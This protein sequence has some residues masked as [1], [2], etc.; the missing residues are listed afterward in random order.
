[1]TQKP[2]GALILTHLSGE[3][4]CALGKVLA[5]RGFRIKTRSTPNLDFAE[6]EALRPDLLVVMGGPVGVYQQEDY[7]FLKSEIEILKKRLAADKPTIGICL[8]SQ[9]MAAALGGKVYAGKQGKEL[10]WM[11]LTLT[12]AGEK[13]EAAALC[14]SQTNMF[15]WH[16]DT[17]DLPKNCT[18]LASTDTYKNQIYQ[19]GRNGL[20]L[21][22]HPEVTAEQLKEW[23]VMF[24][25]QITG[26]NP[27]IPIDKLRAQTATH[28][29]TLNTQAKLFFNTWLENRGL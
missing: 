12:D 11:P 10:G 15:H 14:G 25:A 19:S 1:M 21:Q 24:T 4:S 27:H 20:G 22:C 8:G 26:D 9:L 18:L 17:F 23:C 5:E 13:H 6:I 2:K 16:G 7:P 29:E 3:G 28:I